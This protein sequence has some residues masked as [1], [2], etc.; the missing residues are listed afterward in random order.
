MPFFEIREKHD[1]KK[2]ITFCILILCKSLLAQGCSDTGFCNL[3]SMKPNRI[4][5]IQGYGKEIKM[6]V[7][8]GKADNNISV[9]GN[10]LK[11]NKKNI[12]KLN[13][14]IPLKIRNTSPNGLTKLFIANLEY[15]IRF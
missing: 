6:D 1:F 2:I 3:N 5:T 4:D 10:Y 11:F 15:R 12:L 9:L 8:H 7:S 14:E 13:M